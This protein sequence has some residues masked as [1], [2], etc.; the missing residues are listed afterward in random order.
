M[1]A[2]AEYAYGT[3]A[4]DFSEFA[5]EHCTQSIDVWDGTPLV[6]EPFELE[7][8]EEALAVNEA[9]IYYWGSVVLV[10]PRKNGKTTLLAAYAL[11]SLLKT[12]GMPE[13]LLCASS[14]KQ[15]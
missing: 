14:D 6:L 4:D 3:L 2:L 15:A 7:Y 11:Y 13:I 5:R 1:S 10:L 8:M 9:A 12:D